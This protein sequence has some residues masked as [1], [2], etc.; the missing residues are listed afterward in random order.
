[1]NRSIRNRST[2]VNV[3][4][5]LGLRQNI[6]VECGGIKSTPFSCKETQALFEGASPRRFCAIRTVAERK[7]GTPY[8]SHWVSINAKM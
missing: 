3:N 4:V 8:Y 2:P 5:F 7:L 1:M 6:R